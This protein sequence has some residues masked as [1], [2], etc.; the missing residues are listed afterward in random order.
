MTAEL[1][2]RDFDRIAGAPGA[3]T[4]LRRF[5]LDLAVSGRLVEQDPSETPVA[6]G[7]ASTPRSKQRARKSVSPLGSPVSASNLPPGWTTRTVG[8]VAECLDYMRQPINIEE[9]KIRTAGK[10]SQEL[11]PY[12]GATQQ[13]GWIDDYLF[14]EELV[15]LGEDGV[16]YLDPFRHKAYLI[17]GKT[18]VNNHAH[19]LRAHLTTGPFLFLLSTHL[20]IA[21]ASWERPVPS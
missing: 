4:W 15:L 17:A 2:L 16:P 10:D 8:E 3:T 9:R 20:T 7:E 11:F 21:V 5:V 18:W 6:N 19:V 14:D 12:Y 13:Q 1:L